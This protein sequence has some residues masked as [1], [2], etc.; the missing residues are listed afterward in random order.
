[1]LRIDAATVPGWS[2]EI[3]ISSR[4]AQVARIATFREQAAASYV[5]PPIHFDDPEPLVVT[6][7]HFA[8]ISGTQGLVPGS[9]HTHGRFAWHQ[10]FAMIRE[11]KVHPAGTLPPALVAAGASYDNYYH[12]IAESVGAMLLYRALGGDAATPFILPAP[13]SDWQRQTLALFGVDN[14]LIEIDRHE[15]GVFDEAMLTNLISRDY[16]YAPHPALLDMFTERGRI[17]PRSS[18]AGR[19]IYVAR[20]DAGDRRRM[21]NEPQLC[22]M[23]EAK[24]FEIVISGARPVAEQAALF[25]DA[26][27]IVAPHGAALT[28]LLFAANGLEG[29]TVVELLQENYLGRGFTKICQGKRLDYRVIVN[30][31]LSAADHHHHSSWEADLPLIAETISTLP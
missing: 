3:Q 2:P 21:V 16:S 9:I 13:T 8:V 6:G 20:M 27:L 15:A 11:M 4:T 1:M 30:P 26:A 28:N 23:L 10:A 17:P 7:R 31:C 18:W 19:R 12:W 25:R 22:A 5:A 14:P 24:G 29:P